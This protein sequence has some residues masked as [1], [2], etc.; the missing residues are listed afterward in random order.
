MYYKVHGEGQPLVLL[1]GAFSAIG[2]S[3]GKILPRLAKSRKVIA[4]ELQG[5]DHTTDIDR[6]PAEFTACR[7][8]DSLL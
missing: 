2:T 5:H 3:F 8:Q 1:H 6:R 4:F 7:A